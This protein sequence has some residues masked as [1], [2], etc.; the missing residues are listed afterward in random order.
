MSVL[1]SNFCRQG[2]KGGGQP[3]RDRIG[4]TVIFHITAYFKPPYIIDVWV[5]L[6]LNLRV[7]IQYTI[8]SGSASHKLVL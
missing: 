4:A 7:S 2:G 1:N 6:K 3:D 8:N 5:E